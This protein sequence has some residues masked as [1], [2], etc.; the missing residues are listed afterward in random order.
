MDEQGAQVGV[1]GYANEVDMNWRSRSVLLAVPVAV[2]LDRRLEAGFE[3]L[4]G[5]D[6]QIE[7]RDQ[8]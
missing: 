4:L 7:Q 2:R 8:K 3:F 1:A 6:A 5:E